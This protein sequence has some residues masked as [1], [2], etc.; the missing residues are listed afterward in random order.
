MADP[1]GVRRPGNE[2]K[3]EGKAQRMDIARSVAGRPR[4]HGLVVP[5]VVVVVV[6]VVMEA[7]SVPTPI[8]SRAH[9]IQ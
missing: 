7:E 6:V 3:R 9:L 1:H 2:P 5:V 8:G 4:G